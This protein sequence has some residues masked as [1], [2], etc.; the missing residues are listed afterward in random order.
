MKLRCKIDLC[1]SIIFIVTELV[2][3]VPSILTFIFKDMLAGF[4]T[5][6]PFL[7]VTLLFMSSFSGYIIIK[8]DELY[9]R[10]GFILK[11]SIPY[12]NIR[13]L[14]KEKTVLSECLLGMK[15]SLEHVLI[16]YNKYDTT[17]VS[18][19]NNDLFIEEVNKKIKK[20]EN[21]D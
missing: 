20:M 3:L 12:E 6:A 4:V 10:Y 2:L 13:A 19:R 7:L 1:Y 11:R 17:C 8:E 14:I 21:L 15:N 5:L 16:K 9:I 18:V